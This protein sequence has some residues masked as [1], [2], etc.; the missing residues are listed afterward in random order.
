M[1]T[2]AQNL[3]REMA[4]AYLTGTAPRTNPLSCPACQKIMTSIMQ[5]KPNFHKAKMNE[6]LFAAK[7]YENKTGLRSSKKQTQSKPISVS[8]AWFIV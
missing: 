7:G 6:N 5:N 3:S 1:S 2:E 4:H 8:A